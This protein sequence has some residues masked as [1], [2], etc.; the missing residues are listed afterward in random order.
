MYVSVIVWAN[1][2]NF[3]GIEDKLSL[4]FSRLFGTQNVS[5][6]MYFHTAFYTG[7]L[8]NDDKIS[9]NP[10]L[11]SLLT[12]CCFYVKSVLFLGVNTCKLQT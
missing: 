10:I 4:I 1:Q 9:S 3:N 8:N 11:L 6:Y 5:Y 12:W 2:F 7:T